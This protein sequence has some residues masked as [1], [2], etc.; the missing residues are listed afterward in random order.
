MKDAMNPIMGSTAGNGSSGS[1][2]VKETCTMGVV[3]TIVW[4]VW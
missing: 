4:M 1:E 2:V 3:F